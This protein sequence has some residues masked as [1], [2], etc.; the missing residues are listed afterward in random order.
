MGDKNPNKAPKKPKKVEKKS[1]AA[2]STK[3]P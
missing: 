2:P 1:V 3:N